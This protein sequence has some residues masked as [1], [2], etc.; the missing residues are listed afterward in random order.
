MNNLRSVILYLF[1]ACS[2]AVFFQCASLVGGGTE[3]VNTHTIIGRIYYD[4]DGGASYTQVC[5]LPEQ[6]DPVKK[7]LFDRLILDT[8]DENGEY[9]FLL[10]ASGRFS[11][12]AVHL[13]NRTR[14]LLTGITVQSETT[15]VAPGI[16][17]NPGTVKVMLPSGIDAVYG[18]VYIPETDIVALLNGN[19][20]FAMLDSVP[21]GTIPSVTYSAT[22]SST[23][24]VFRYDVP[25]TPGDTTVIFMPEWK[26]SKLLVL[27]TTPGGASVAGDVINFPVLVRLT[28]SNF[29]FGKARSGGADI[30]FTKSNGSPLPLEIELWDPVNS[31]AAIWVKVDTVYGNNNTQS[32]VMYWGNPAAVSTSSGPAVFDTGGAAGFQGVWHMT[33][34]GNDTAIDA[35]ANRY[36]GVPVN[37]TP[38]SAVTGMVGGA[39]EFDGTTTYV[40]M[41]GTAGGTLSF[42]EDGFYAVSA[43]VYVD[44]VTHAFNHYIIASKGNMQYS[45]ELM[46]SS[47]AEA[48]GNNGW[49]FCE[50]Q[51]IAGW[52]V[53]VAS[54]TTKAWA[55]IVGMR[56][57]TMQYLYV[58]G[59]CVDSVI[60]SVSS[61]NSPR[62]ETNDLV[63]GK[64]NPDFSYYFDG[65]IDEVRISRG[66]LSADR[67]KLC[68]MNQKSP[69]VLVQ[70]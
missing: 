19:S 3:D 13:L 66:A 46:D 61:N 18:Y 9:Q 16:L 36:H 65:I 51:N 68:Y 32:I 63:L 67:I 45:L 55:H 2:A 8:T 62:D 53:T 60:R 50:T 41:P 47:A 31:A 7:Q 39:R 12:Q 28:S 20:T 58:N 25:V 49:E 64:K 44:T 42:P 4:K 11:V 33:G 43:W 22:N 70:F 27:T 17:R 57:G 38:L 29:D 10:K 23:R 40:T 1:P 15:Y 14:V 59:V 54:M 26:Y 37:M 21:A 24:R 30:R 35:T 52:D 56:I 48:S 34:A 5:L 6:Y 69:G